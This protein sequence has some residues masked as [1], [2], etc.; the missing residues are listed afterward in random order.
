M[1]FTSMLQIRWL[2]RLLWATAALLA[3][4]AL[5]WL[6][7]PPLLKS[8]AEQQGSKALGRSVTLGA[9]A[10]N[11][12]TLEL[13]LSDLKI[14]SA[15]GKS[16][17]LS[18]ARLYADAE[19]QS[20]FRL[21]PVIDA[22]TIDQPHIALTHLGGGR[23]DIDDVLQRLQSAPTEPASSPLRFAVYN[24]V[25]NDGSA[26]FVDH[27]GG[28][29]SGNTGNTSNTARSH[30]LRKLE[31]SLPFLSSFDSQ[32]DVTVQPKLAFEL[33]GSR[34]DSTAQATPFAQS[35]KGELALQVA[36]LDIAPYLPYLPQSL[37]VRIKGAVLDSALKVSFAQ[38]QV[39]QLL[40][41]GALKLSNIRIDDKTGAPL[42]QAASLQTV[43]KAFRPLEQVLELE[44]LTLTAPTFALSRK[45]GLDWLA[46]AGFVSDKPSAGA[47]T[48]ARAAAPVAATAATATTAAS[49]AS[50]AIG[51]PAAAT[52]GGWKVTL[53]AF[54]LNDGKLRLTDASVS[55]TA[56][57][58]LSDTQIKLSDVA[59]PFAKP[60]QLELSAKLQS[61][62]GG[63]AKPARLELSGQGTDAAGSVQLRLSDLGL[64][65]AAPYLSAYLLPRASGVLE[66]ELL[67]NWQGQT[68][69]VGAKRLALND[70]ALAPPAGKTEITARELPSF[71]RLELT[72][73]ALDVQKQA[74]SV[75]KLSLAGTKARV[76]RGDDGQWMFTRWLPAK[77][78]ATA[79]SSAPAAAGKPAAPWSVSLG[80]VALDDATLSLVDRLP[81]KNVFLELSALQLRLQKVTL[82]GKK[83]V[84]LSLSAKVRSVR[85]DP[86]S[87]RFDGSLM[88][89]PLLAQG[90]LEAKQFPAQALAPYFLAEWPL[91][92][93]RAD[94]SFKG[95][96][97]Y[98]SLSG[99]PDVQLSGDAALEEFKLHSALKSA[100]GAEQNEELLNWKALSVPGIEFS[101][102]PAKPLHLT[103][104]EVSLSDFFARLIINAE[105]RLVLQDLVGGEARATD[106]AATAAAASA[107][108]AVVAKGAS[109]NDPVIE[110]GAI[111]LVNGH[112]AFSDRFIKPNYSADLTALSGSLGR[113]SSQP[114]QGE[115]QMADLELRGRAEGTAS[116]EI[117]GKVN[118]LAKPLALDIQAKVRDLE[119]SPLSSYA[120]KYAGYGIERGKLSVD[121]GYVIRPDGQLQASNKIV[122][123]QLVFGDAVAG[124]ANALPVKLAVA[125]LA[126][127]KGVIDLDVPVSGSL[128]DPQFRI[129][130]IVWK[131]LGNLIA[132]ALTSPFA[133]ISGLA[134][135]SGGGDGAGD[136][137]NVAFDAGS[138]SLGA[139]ALPGLDQVAKALR[140]KPALRL[141]IEGTASLEREADAMQRARLQELLLAEKRRAAA[142]AGQDVTAVA[143]VTAEETPALMKEVYRR[144]RIKKPRNLVGLAKD[145]SPAEM[146]ALLLASLSVDADNV[147][148]LA[149]NRSLAVREYLSA[150]QVPT[151]RLFLGA[152]KTAPTD[153]AWQPRVEL[154]I[155]QR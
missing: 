82:D 105:G 114:A 139:A 95:Q 31:I 18:I 94:T 143:A 109:P 93:Q 132:K 136:L 7:L 11:P 128:N 15:D 13:T 24:V 97:R 124:A 5:A 14:A 155:E 3:L 51:T 123:N 45:P 47:K 92:L 41:S 53:Q 89:D 48:A 142:S 78:E 37:P 86:G 100:S 81:A 130:P 4:W 17:Q 19:L 72:D 83:P 1:N 135:S 146:E 119:L 57:L 20:L 134:G 40:V 66:G 117:T 87:L 28:N 116:L 71:K 16:T 125:L 98:A 80:E 96:V 36:G 6:A 23:Y 152:V 43:L 113:F 58:L 106:A 12:L 46:S 101:M 79:A 107:P 151:E 73:V 140:D 154:N 27:I 69:Q 29:T 90:A 112:V 137:S 120:I 131:V 65:L 85:T 121:L 75:G 22:V 84:P 25:L 34:F 49:T 38:A 104:R 59:W 50:S 56:R 68:L 35:R 153:A 21:A 67:A 55:P 145:L 54:Q 42:L 147:R 115:L 129:W 2:R 103:L 138:A 110:V 144:S 44:S 102:S 141:T 52:P 10:F 70:F 150:H 33:N 77:P 60:A 126:D 118:P 74:A 149:L 99:G 108:S 64:P 122:L 62:D 76:A 9:V 127:S 88:W 26:D 91:D 30:S 133:L 111:K 39:N 8:Q 148:Q 32:R 63:S 61:L